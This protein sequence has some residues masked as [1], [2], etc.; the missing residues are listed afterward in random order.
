MGV[1]P[2]VII[3]L[4][5][6][7]SLKFMKA[8]IDLNLRIVGVRL[9]FINSLACLMPSASIILA[10]FSP[11][12]RFPEKLAFQ[13]LCSTNNLQDFVGNGCL[14]GFVVAQS[15]FFQHFL[16]IVCCLIH[17]RHTRPVLCCMR[18]ENGFV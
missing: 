15:K 3:T 2:S 17:R 8:S 6:F 1:L 10:D 13:C 12:A 18:V 5:L 4:L 16:R 11:S 9:E 7:D 14:P